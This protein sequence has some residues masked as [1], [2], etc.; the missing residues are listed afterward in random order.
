MNN[1]RYTH[2]QGAENEKNCL[3]DSQ[4][5]S[6]AMAYVKSQ[7]FGNLYSSEEAICRGT[8]LRDLDLPFSKGGCRK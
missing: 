6:Y 2:P 8:L 3:C 5:I 1:N 4:P 7:N